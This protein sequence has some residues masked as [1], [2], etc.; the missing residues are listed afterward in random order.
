M[1]ANRQ[2]HTTADGSGRSVKIIRPPLCADHADEVPREQWSEL[3]A[4]RRNFCQQILPSDC[5]MLLFFVDDA[6]GLDPEQVR[7]AIDGLHQIQP[8]KPIEY[9]WAI[10][11]GKHG[12]DRK[13]EK[14]QR[15]A[16][17]LA[18]KEGREPKDVHSEWMKIANA[19]QANMTEAQLEAKRTWLLKRLNP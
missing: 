5:R 18:K 8:D 2:Q 13:S 6:L 11:L 14:V 17:Q 9:D 12:G 3:I 15:L 16:N 19:R 4:E 7:W 10:K 1:T